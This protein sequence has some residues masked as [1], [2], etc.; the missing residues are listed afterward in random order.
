MLKVADT[1]DLKPRLEYLKQVV[2]G[3]I[4][5]V[6]RV[7]SAMRPQLLEELGLLAALEGLATQLKERA[8]VR[9]V[10]SS[11]VADDLVPDELAGCLYR[12]A[13]EAFTNILRHS[14]ADKVLI[15]LRQRNGWLQLQI[16]DNGIGITDQQLAASDSFGLMGMSERVAQCGGSLSITA[17]SGGG[18]VV[19][20]HIPLTKHG[21]RYE[22]YTD[23]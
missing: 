23:C 19:E 14:G 10:F 12:V 15:T 1:E 6:Q 18:T 22:A 16:S 5:T 13:Q 11:T 21:D 9:T 3:T 20:A 17:R 8:G 4:G 7:V 2:E